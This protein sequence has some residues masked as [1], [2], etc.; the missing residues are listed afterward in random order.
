[1]EV[2]KVLCGANSKEGQIADGL[3]RM[4]GDPGPQGAGVSTS[5]QAQVSY[6]R[7]WEPPHCTDTGTKDGAGVRERTAQDP[8]LKLTKP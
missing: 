5:A 3:Q 6:G 8:G 2:R 4:H 7:H 1:M